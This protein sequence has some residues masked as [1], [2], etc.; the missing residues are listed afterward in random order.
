MELSNDEKELIIKERERKEKNNIV[1]T[2]KIDL[3]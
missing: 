3:S 2:Y 1:I